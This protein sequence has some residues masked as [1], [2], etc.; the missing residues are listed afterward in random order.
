MRIFALFLF[1]L[2]LNINTICAQSKDGVVHIKVL[3]EDGVGLAG[4]TLKLFVNNEFVRGEVTD[5]EGRLNLYLDFDVDYRLQVGYLGYTDQEVPLSLTAERKEYSLVFKLEPSNT[6]ISTV[7]VSIG[8]YNDQEF[9]PNLVQTITIDEV[10]KLPATFFDPA[11]AAQNFAGVANNNDQANGISIRGNNPEFFKW[12]LEGVEIVNPN[13][14][15]NAGTFSDRPSQNAGGVNIL[16]AQMLSQ[17]QFYKSIYPAAYQNA[18]SGIMGMSLRNGDRNKRK[19][20]AQIGLIGLELSSEGPIQKDK[21]ATYLF[22]YRFSTV[23]LL[24]QLGLDF[25]G[26]AIDFQDLAFNFSFPTK[27]GV[28]KVFA[29]G[30]LSNNVFTA[31]E[32]EEREEEKD[33]TDIDFSGDMGLVGVNFDTY[34]NTKNRLNITSILSANTTSRSSELANLSNQLLINDEDQQRMLSTKISVDHKLEKG[35][36]QVGAFSNLLTYDFSTDDQLGNESISVRGES[37]NR[38]GIFAQF[39]YRLGKQWRWSGGVNLAQQFTAAANNETLVEPRTSFSFHPSKAHT[40]QV[41][42]GLYSQSNAPRT[43]HT[44]NTLTNT[45]LQNTKSWQNVLGYTYRTKNIEWRTEAFYQFLYE[46]PISASDI[47]NNFS[48]L[49]G[50]D[51]LGLQSLE[52]EGI[53]RNIGIET[54]IR[55]TPDYLGWTWGANAT[56]Y[57]SE[58]RPNSGEWRSTRFDGQ[59]IFNVLLGKEWVPKAKATLGVHVRANYLGGFRATPI[60]LSAS[61]IQQTTVFDEASAFTLSQEDYFRVDFSI[62]RRVEHKK[63]T[64]TISLDI[65]NVTNRKNESFSFYDSFLDRIVRREQLGLLPIINYRIQ[66]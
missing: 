43:Y 33:N 49:N 65:Q 37:I 54:S 16:S 52:S 32:E 48:V 31:P 58:Y 24:T 28:F 64:S 1:S 15:S 46:V 66:F 18:L 4:A 22:N 29:V 3:N 17:S 51:G 8:R 42:S 62:F 40:I 23:G 25:G 27:N 11:R 9:L 50:I 19:H 34:L 2:L 35:S 14:T 63:F 61:R 36:F 47:S 30:G 60:D 39:D 38:V 5:T 26:E 20:F 56:L 57:Q 21:E 6:Y 59:Y 10:R 44:S 45:N 12:Y 13:H 7:D 55:K 53:G 41:V